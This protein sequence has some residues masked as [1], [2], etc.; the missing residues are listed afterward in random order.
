MS[1]ERGGGVIFLLLGIYGVTFSNSLSMGRWDEPGPGVF[2]LAVSIL[3]CVSGI[4][5]LIVGK[6]KVG[7]AAE[8]DW[9]RLTKLLKVPALTVVLTAA[10][11][12][13]MTRIGYLAGSTLFLVL[14]LFLVSQYR[15]R[16]AIALGV[17]IGIGNWLF[18][19]KLLAIP[20]PAVGM[21]IF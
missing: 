1:K 15:L 10:F 14:A 3:L 2:P 21:W 13:S 5:W 12:M 19:V 6:P 20:L 4:A 8:I 17:I 9:P 16:T 18:F 11:V 7:E